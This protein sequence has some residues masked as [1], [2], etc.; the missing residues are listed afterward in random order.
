MSKR[1]GFTLIELLVVI[2]IIGCLIAILLPVLQGARRRGMVLTCPIAYVGEDGRIHL[3]DPNGKADLAY[4]L[5]AS[6]YIPNDPIF[7]SPSGRRIGFTLAEWKGL[8]VPSPC[9]PAI[10]DPMSGRIAIHNSSP[11][12]FRQWLDEGR[13]LDEWYA[14]YGLRNADTGQLIEK[15]QWPFDSPVHWLSARLPPHMDGAHVARIHK[16]KVTYIRGDMSLG[17]TICAW[18]YTGWDP[19]E[20]DPNGEWLAWSSG[21]GNE[22]SCVMLKRLGS[23]P[24]EDPIR[25]ETNLKCVLFCDWTEGG[26]LLVQIWEPGASMLAIMGIDGQIIRRV[27]STVS[28]WRRPYAVWRKYGHQ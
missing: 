4:D 14:K 18:V 28:N 5:P 20:V 3:T 12:E 23:N 27:P 8:G 21:R 22:S 9:S 16:G 6:F 15:R 13:Y 10:L 25:L 19:F 17:K 2:G 26:E 1:K 24:S 11:G 7:W